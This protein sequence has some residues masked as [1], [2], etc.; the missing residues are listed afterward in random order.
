M[1]DGAGLVALASKVPGTATLIEGIEEFERQRL[2]CLFSGNTIC[3]E[4]IYGSEIY[5]KPR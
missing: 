4:S 1:S 3:T 5:S 2:S